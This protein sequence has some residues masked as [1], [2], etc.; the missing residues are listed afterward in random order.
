M[1]LDETMLLSLEPLEVSE[2]VFP[3]Q[4]V[5]LAKTILRNHSDIMSDFQIKQLLNLL[6]ED[7]KYLGMTISIYDQPTQVIEDRKQHGHKYIDEWCYEDSLNGT[8]GGYHKLGNIVLFPFNHSVKNKKYE[9][10]LMQLFLLQDLF[11]EIRHAFQRV[12]M[13]KQYNAPYITTDKNGYRSQWI[14]RDANMFAQRMLEK[15]RD[16]INTILGIDFDWKSCWGRFYI[17]INKG[18]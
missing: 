16:S 6:Y 11:H 4:R 9:K 5:K 15:N 1:S 17:T 18:A 8:L 13:R 12:H 14:E 7:Y 3:N 10:G 2:T